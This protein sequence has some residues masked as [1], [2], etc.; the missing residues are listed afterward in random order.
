MSEMINWYLYYTKMSGNPELTLD[1]QVSYYKAA[2]AV[3]GNIRKEV[4]ADENP[5]G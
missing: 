4:K 1:Q 3:L 5:C 2:Q